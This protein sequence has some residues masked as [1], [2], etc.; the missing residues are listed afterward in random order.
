MSV[1]VFK[2]GGSLLTLPDLGLRMARI[3]EGQG[4]HHPLLVVGGG[5]T[6]DIV[7]SWD[8]MHQLSAE[9][10]H[11]L[12]LR[13]MSLNEALLAELL[14]NARVVSSRQDAEI[15][16]TEGRTAI[17]SAL[18]FLQSEEGG[19]AVPLE[20]T[21]NAT[22]DSIAAWVA[23]QWPADRLVLLKSTA[24]ESSAIDPY[25]GR[26]HS[27]LSRVEWVN[28]RDERPTFEPFPPLPRK[29]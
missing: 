2:L 6:A 29:H 15:A 18:R 12:A 9:S 14:P 4:Q 25:F 24:V 8:A 20:H 21:W 28:V 3:L 26:L 22:S 16:W 17:L 10:S 13:A 27:R 19:S 1:T 11:W 23:V 7:R 5:A